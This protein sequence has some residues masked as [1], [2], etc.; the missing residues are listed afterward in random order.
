MATWEFVERAASADEALAWVVEDPRPLHEWLC[1]RIEAS[2]QVKRS[3]IHRSRLNQTFAYQILLGQRHPSRDKLLQLSFGLG[4]AI[5]ECS[6]MLERG[7]HNALRP[8]CRRDVIIAYC[9][10]NGLGIDSCDDLLWD[11]GERTLISAGA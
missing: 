3:V 10:H 5:G 9:L 8:T 2:G 1:E 7:G 6:E 4:L 11:A